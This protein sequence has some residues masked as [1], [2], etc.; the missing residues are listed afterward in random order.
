M[1][2]GCGRPSPRARD[3]VMSTLARLYYNV[4]HLDL[5][6]VVVVSSR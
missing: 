4:V 3:L 5:D 1:R 6:L 2:I